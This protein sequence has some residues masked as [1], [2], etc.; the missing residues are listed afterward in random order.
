MKTI[1][2]EALLRWAYV[3]ELPNGEVDRVGPAAPRAGWASM[4]LFGELLT[5]VAGTDVRNIYGLAPTGLARPPHP[6]AV[7]VFHA[8]ST[9][10]GALF[11]VPAGWNPLDDMGDLGEDGAAA[12]RRGLDRL[13]TT[14]DGETR[15]RRPLVNL[16]LRHAICGGVPAWEFDAP[17]A[18]L[19]TAN[20]K[21]CWFRRIVEEV[22]GAF[23][24]VRMEVEVDGYDARRQ[25]PFPG[26]YRKTVLTPDPAE[27]VAARAEYQ[28]WHAALA[29]LATVLIMPLEEH[30]VL[31]PAL[32]ARPWAPDGEPNLT[33]KFR[34]W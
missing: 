6:D 33:L 21:P 29:H 14:V 19:L 2:I 9:L 5:R 4:S 11:N 7:T 16:V 8:V 15:L 25:R 28:L 34:G 26:A 12:I 20:G 18:K 32:P 23:G 22:P 24:P 27:A 10:E 1:G 3:D 13:T 17:E 30:D 31:P